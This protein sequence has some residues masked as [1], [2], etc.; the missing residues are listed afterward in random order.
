MNFYCQDIKLGTEAGNGNSDGENFTDMNGD[1]MD[2]LCLEV[3]HLEG[4]AR[5]VCLKYLLLFRT[6][7]SNRN[8]SILIHSFRK[9]M[10][11]GSY[12]CAL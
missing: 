11:N 8:T 3:L 6:A 12:F 9:I 2:S 10:K 1:M 5:L 4:I 7:D